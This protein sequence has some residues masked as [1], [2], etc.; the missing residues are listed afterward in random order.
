MNKLADYLRNYE[1]VLFESNLGKVT[2]RQYLA[3]VRAFVLWCDSAQHTDPRSREEAENLA[4]NF[5]GELLEQ[6]M[7]PSSVNCMSTSICH[8]LRTALG[9]QATLQ[10]F[11]EISSKPKSLSSQDR[12]RLLHELQSATV[13]TPRD[14]AVTLVFLMAGLR[15]GECSALNVEDIDLE[16]G[17]LLIGR[18]KNARR[19]PI[20]SALR[21]AM[22]QWLRM[23]CAPAEEQALFVNKQ[24]QRL[25]LPSIVQTVKKVGRQA[26]LDLSAQQLRNTCI[27]GLIRKGNDSL[28]VADVIGVDPATLR[29]FVNV[30]QLQA[31]EI[32]EML[33]T[34]A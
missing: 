14:R 32:M 24:G 22:I 30:S 23:R 12:E 10:R 25:S 21:E 17:Q 5:L 18:G 34:I 9:I 28:I 26:R 8:F 27:D 33:A 13:V 29:H 1:D 2:Q 16:Q 15:P 11:E 3:H 19:T 20:N 31:V 7:K 4:T 6:Q